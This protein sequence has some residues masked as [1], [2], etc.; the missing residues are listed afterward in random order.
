MKSRIIDSLSIYHTTN[1][2]SEN[3]LKSRIHEII[4]EAETPAGKRFDVI[5]LVLILLSVLVVMLESVPSV[6]V[7]Y[8]DYFP[9]L[10]WGFTII[11]TIEYGLRLYSVKKP[12]VYAK[13]FYGIIDV[14]AILPAY[15]AILFEGSHYFVV[16]RAL[17]LMRVFRIFKLGHFLREGQV[18]SGAL[19][20]S[21]P[22]ITVFLVFIVLLVTIIGSIMY[23]VEGGS[24]DHFQSIPQS[25]YWAIVTLTTVG[26]GDLTPQSNFGRFLASIVMILG[27]AVIAVPTGIVTAEMTNYTE[28]PNNTY[29]CQDCGNEEHDDDA[30]YCKH[31]GEHLHE[32]EHED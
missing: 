29:S 4:F 19:R 5:L 14:L 26:Y 24:N 28:V 15:L 32:H 8:K 3:Q 21:Q 6:A 7:K 1:S 18:I 16:I 25:I 31:C 11:F 27:Y 13:S 2:M 30:D 9:L 22:K 20:A 10:E 12:W 17:R 23:L